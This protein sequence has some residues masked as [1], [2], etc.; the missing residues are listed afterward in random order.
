MRLNEKGGLF[1]LRNV[2]KTSSK[3]SFNVFIHYKRKMREK[4]HLELTKDIQ[5]DDDLSWS[6]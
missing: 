5:T 2:S 1:G 3:S 6:L 4:H